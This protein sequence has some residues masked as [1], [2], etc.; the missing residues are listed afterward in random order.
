MTSKEWQQ[1]LKAYAKADHRKVT[2]QLLNTV[3]PYIGLLGII[4]YLGSIGV[5]FWILGPLSIIAS[6]LMVRIFIFF[7]DCTHQ[8][9]VRKT[10]GNDRIGKILGFFVF[11]AYEPW[12]KEHSIHHGAVG[13]LQRRGVGDVWTLTSKE[14]EA[15]SH[16]RRFIYRLFRNPA[17]LFILAPVFLFVVLQRIPKTSSKKKEKKNIWMTNGALLAYGI[18]MSLIFGWQTFVLYQ[19]LIITIASSA[20]VWLFY[21]QHQFEDVYWANSDEWNL[22]D[23]ALQGSTYYKLPALFEWVS[24]YIGYHHIH[25]LNARIPN[26][27]LKACYNNIPELQKTKTVTL[28]DSFKLAALEIYDEKRQ[29]LVS[30]RTYKRSKLGFNI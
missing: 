19:L 13:N 8:S 10:K 12:K 11:T 6:A 26:Y 30:Y 23:A 29:K 17:F 14:Y 21:V 4:F 24:G 27:N 3:L 5:S 28:K 2:I 1:S 15:S 18:I 22:A 16:F 7:H 20:G 9:F 25:H